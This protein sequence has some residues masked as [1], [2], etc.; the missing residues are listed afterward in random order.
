MKFLKFAAAAAVT[1]L[2]FSNPAN[3]A[4]LLGSTGSS[5]N[6]VTN[7]S[8]A[9]LVSFDL[10]LLDFSGARLNFVLEEADLA[11]PLSLN[12]IIMNLRGLSMP[13]F[14]FDLQGIA[15]AGA[16]SVTA[17]FGTIGSVSHT[18]S[19][20]NIAFAQGETTDF[21]FG[22]P[23]ELN[24][25]SNWLLDTTGMR[26]GDTFSITAQVPEPST[27][28]LL[29]PMLGMAGFMAKRRRKQG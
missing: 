27:L 24:G 23:L 28:A 14:N 16:G 9:G 8:Q 29:L 10:E 19:N 6:T 18:A 4:L 21:Y 22:N 13:N 20:A 2:A 1:A 26:A 17:G 15:F 3:A 5:L 12:A 7:Y 11:G 25:Y